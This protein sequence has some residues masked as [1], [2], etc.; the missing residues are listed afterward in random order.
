VRHVLVWRGLDAPRLEIA[1][2]EVAGDTLR[3]TGTQIGIAY[4]LRYELEAELLRLELVGERKLEWELEGR[5]FFD[6][7]YSPLLNSLPVIRDR[8]LSGKSAR[9]YV[10]RLVSVPELGVVDAEQRYEPLGAGRVR[11]TSGDF[12]ADLDFDDQGFVVHYEGLAERVD[13]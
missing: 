8:L 13:E 4:E 6:L 10:M 2:V 9:D 12:A 11:F 3:A 7:A 1:R 5:D